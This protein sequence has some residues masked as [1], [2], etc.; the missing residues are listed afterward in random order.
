MKIVKVGSLLLYASHL[1]HALA[2]ALSFLFPFFSPMGTAL[3]A[4]PSQSFLSFLSF[5]FWTTNILND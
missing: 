1:A 5:L 4:Q 3:A 2:L